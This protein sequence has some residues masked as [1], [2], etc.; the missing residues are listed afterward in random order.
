MMTEMECTQTPPCDD[1]VPFDATAW[2]DV[3]MGSRRLAEL[4]QVLPVTIRWVDDPALHDPMV[5]ERL[6]GPAAHAV[7]ACSEGDGNG[8]LPTL[9]AAQEQLLF[10]RFNYARWRAAQAQDALRTNGPEAD[11][12]SQFIFWHRVAVRT[13]NR[14]VCAN[15]RLVVKIAARRKRNGQDLSELISDGNLAL[16]RAVE[17]FDASRGLKFSTYAWSAIENA[18]RRRAS[19]RDRRAV[20]EFD[21]ALESGDAPAERREQHEQACAHEVAAIV[22]WNTAGLTRLERTIIQRRYGLDGS[23]AMTLDQVCQEVGRT[24]ERV[25]QVQNRALQKIRRSLLR[26]YIDRAE[27]LRAA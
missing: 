18:L 12:A 19:R 26:T 16:F 23:P 4:S 2:R 1:A 24:R 5:P 3:K 15:L 21:P 27:P 10:L 11:L 8:W 17:G 22:A 25:R 7:L 14:I 20:V 13:R 9:N 6:F